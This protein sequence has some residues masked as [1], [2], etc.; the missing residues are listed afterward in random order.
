MDN[1]EN[2]QQSEWKD[3]IV[4]PETQT[5]FDLRPSLEQLVADTK[6][7]LK[8]RQ[9]QLELQP[10][11]KNFSTIM[12]I[13]S[14][15]ANFLVLFGGTILNFDNLPPD[16]P[17]YYDSS[18]KTWQVADKSVYLF[19]PFVYLLWSGAMIR[20]IFY[21]FKYDRRLAQISST[22][23]IFINV[24]SFFVISEISRLIA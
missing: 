6:Y 3:L 19:L 22:I 20:L 8:T 21:V 13:I 10:F 12:A 2:E 16:V 11:W 4:V 15:V 5:S 24:L 18:I 17:V 9:N 1:Q 23:I 14:T 7:R